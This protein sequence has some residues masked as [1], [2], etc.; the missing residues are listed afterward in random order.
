MVP[1]H[2]DIAI[3]GAGPAAWAMAAALA[4]TGLSVT[5]VSPDP[6]ARWTNTYGSWIDVVDG[7]VG[8]LLGGAEPWAAVY[9][10]VKVVGDRQ[11][12]A[13][14]AYGRL[15][16]DIVADA[17]RSTAE[18]GTLTLVAGSVTNV[19]HD[20]TGS[21]VRTSSRRRIDATIVLDGAGAATPFVAR[22]ERTAPAA[23]QVAYG[24][25][26]SFRDGAT[27][28]SEICTLMDWR[29]P[30]RRV[31]SFCY[32]LPLGDGR[33]LVE[34]TVLAARPALSFIDLEHRLNDR[35]RADGFV[36]ETVFA[37]ET[38]SFP[39]D[40]PLPDRDQRVVGLGAA[41]SLVHPATGYSLAASFRTAPR[42]AG[43][44]AAALGRNNSTPASVA[45][46]AWRSVWSDDRL[47]A[48][49]LESYGLER[50]LTMDQRDCRAFFDAFFRLPTATTAAYLDGEVGASELAAVM[51]KVFRAV[52][53]RLQRRLASGNPL[54]LARNLL[55]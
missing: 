50:V 18:R 31:P 24:I 36:V 22:P 38:V 3:V 32:T 20:E 45:T 15:A 52:P 28:P 26:A 23:S 9:D 44:L 27:P 16:N 41:A 6:L 17:L 1:A 21:I 25:V 5:L 46:E 30:D 2:C 35:L 48:R 14:R 33:W 8:P 11:Q 43:V 10:T 51:W 12:N 34:E 39:M 53:P 13:G 47:K 54:T 40:L 55:R 49:R 42:L 4:P 7:S 29:G 37:T 19:E